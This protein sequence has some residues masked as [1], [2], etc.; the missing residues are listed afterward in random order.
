[1]SVLDSL[2]ERRL[3]DAELAS[4]NRADAV[5]VAVDV[6]EADRKSPGEIA[7]L[8][9]ATERW[10][11]GLVHVDEGWRVVAS[12]QLGADDERFDAM[13]HCEDAIRAVLDET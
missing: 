1:M 2:P 3:T 8:L 12:Q 7:G 5:E 6:T 10:V 13:Q 4:L 11:K 9:L